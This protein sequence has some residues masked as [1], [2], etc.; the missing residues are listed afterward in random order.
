MCTTA[1]DSPLPRL[2]TCRIHDVPSMVP[3]IRAIRPDIVHGQGQDR[4]SLAALRAGFPTVITPHGVFFIESRMLQRHRFDLLG[5]L[6]KRLV[7]SMEEEVFR[8]ASDMIIIS[9]YL[10]EI[11]GPMLS[12]R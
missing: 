7:N 12:A 1:R 10:P 2:A 11:Y 4:H 6:K 9:R 8:R 5:M 3:V